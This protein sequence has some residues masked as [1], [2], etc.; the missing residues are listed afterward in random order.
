MAPVVAFSTQNITFFV[1]SPEGMPTLPCFHGGITWCY[2]QASCGAPL[3]GSPQ[4]GSFFT[5]DR[6]K[7]IGGLPDVVTIMEGKVRADG[8]R[9]SWDEGSGAG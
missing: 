1:S 8:W 7:V 2:P 4:P 5:A 6:G 3:T 9:Q